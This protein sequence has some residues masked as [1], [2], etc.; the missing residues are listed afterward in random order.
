MTR[1]ELRSKSY[2]ST[3]TGCWLYHGKSKY[4]P[5]RKS[6]EAFKGPIPKGQWVLHTCDIPKCINPK[7]LFLGDRRDNMKDM[8]AKNRGTKN[9]PGRHS[10]KTHCKQ[11][12]PYDKENT[13]LRKSIPGRECRA[14]KRISR[15]KYYDRQTS[16][17][18]MRGI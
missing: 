16:R 14:C 1:D 2:E 9:A 11:G 15:K 4:G 6:F 18:L 13:L 17:P 10:A 3:K 8:Y 12:H 7:H 5:T